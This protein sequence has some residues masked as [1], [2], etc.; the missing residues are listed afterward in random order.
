[1]FSPYGPDPLR[2]IGWKIELAWLPLLAVVSSALLMRAHI[3]RRRILRGEEPRRRRR[4]RSYRTRVGIAIGTIGLLLVS[5][6][7]V[8]AVAGVGGS[9]VRYS[10]EPRLPREVTGQFLRTPQGPV[11]LFAWS[12]P[13]GTYPHDA[14]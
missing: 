3:R 9:S 6:P 4:H 7:F 8:A 14:L 2:A 5:L 11:K 13:Q 12:D 1:A 10:L